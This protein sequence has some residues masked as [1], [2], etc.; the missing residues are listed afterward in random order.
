MAYVVS[1]PKR[2]HDVAFVG[3]GE[4]VSGATRMRPSSGGGDGVVG[5]AK[6]GDKNVARYNRI[7]SLAQ[8]LLEHYAALEESCTPRVSITLTIAIAITL[9]LT[10]I[11]VLYILYCNPYTV[12]PH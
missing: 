1:T 4:E 8:R 11:L 7:V 9:T 2:K 6:V 12:T 10:L 3:N 5:E